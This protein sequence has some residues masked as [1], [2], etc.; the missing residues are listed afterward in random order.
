M[1]NPFLPAP[2]EPEL[3]ETLEDDPILG[4]DESAEGLANPRAL[5][6]VTPL[7]EPTP[8]AIT[9]ESVWLVGASGG[10]GTSTLA[11]LAGGG[12]I[13]G[14]VTAPMWQAPAYIVAATHPAGLDAAAELARANARGELAYEVRGVVLVHDR[15]RLSKATANQA[16]A[17]GRMFPVFMTVPFEPSWRE[18]GIVPAAATVRLRRVLKT[19]RTSALQKGTS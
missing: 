5:R 1:P 9:A 2:E 18:P 10:V 6:N 14:G 19:I 11:R 7:P 12:V 16:R 15:P 17:V 13:D 8:P 4:A 3:V